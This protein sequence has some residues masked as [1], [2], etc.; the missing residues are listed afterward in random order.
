MFSELCNSNSLALHRQERERKRNLYGV[1]QYV[2]EQVGGEVMLPS[3][4]EMALRA[5]DPLG[6]EIK[7]SCFQWGRTKSDLRRLAHALR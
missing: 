5:M 4:T 6:K 3:D 2:L 7:I 1:F